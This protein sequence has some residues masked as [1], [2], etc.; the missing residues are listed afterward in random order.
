MTKLSDI[1]TNEIT[2]DL[3]ISGGADPVANDAALPTTGNS[4]GDLKFNEAKK[5]VH[6]W[7]GTE[8]D[9]IS[10]G[11]QIGPR[12]ITTPP[13]GIT[14]DPDG[15]TTS[16]TVQAV[17]ESGFP[18]TYDW[19]AYSGT[20]IYNSSNL[21]PQLT[22]VT[23][24]NGTFTLTPSTSD[25]DQGVVSFRTKAG[26]GV[27]YTPYVTTLD[28][29]L[30]LGNVTGFIVDQIAT[31][32]LDV[33]YALLVGQTNSLFQSSTLRDATTFTRYPSG[34]PPT[35]GGGFGSTAHSTGYG[36]NRMK[37]AVINAGH[38]LPD[39]Y[40]YAFISSNGQNSDWKFE[41]TSGPEV[42]RY[43]AI[44]G[45]TG[46][47]TTYLKNARMKLIIGGVEETNWRTLTVLNQDQGYNSCLVYDFMA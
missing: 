42:V 5:T 31:N 26:D 12:W 11:P 15:N 28:L 16:F 38:S 30:G 24:S 45:W 41:W 47:N 46:D 10:S 29:S 13:D 2:E 33:W 23:E 9:R 3:G 17:D 27:L 40:Y 39:P 1:K 4:T 14:L 34:N 18:V 35:Y 22:S 37:N 44:T 6:V 43:F 7:D 8:W 21:P 20:T 19:D 25:S 32:S 36:F